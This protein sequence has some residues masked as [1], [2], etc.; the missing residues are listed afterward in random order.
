MKE[1]LKETQRNKDL[2]K[3]KR[4]NETNTLIKVRIQKK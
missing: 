4:K 2:M 1:I 3:K